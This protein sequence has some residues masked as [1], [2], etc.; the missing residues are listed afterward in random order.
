MQAMLPP[1]PVLMQAP[2]PNSSLAQNP[3]EGPAAVA[4]QVPGMQMPP[5]ATPSPVSIAPPSV[6]T[7]V[8]A[9]TP[10]PQAPSMEAQAEAV[11]TPEEEDDSSSG[12]SPLPFIL[13]GA[14]VIGLGVLALGTSRPDPFRDFCSIAD[15]GCH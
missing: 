9:S 11:A 15:V 4:P 1:T 14:A 12:G 2:P 6:E 5:S 8:A 10:P 13:A 7:M 3:T